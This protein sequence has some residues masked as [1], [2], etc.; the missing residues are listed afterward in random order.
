MGTRVVSA[1]RFTHASA[2]R[3]H[4]V[5]GVIAYRAFII[6]TRDRIEA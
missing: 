1:R 3:Y 2:L 4:R 6:V 5:I